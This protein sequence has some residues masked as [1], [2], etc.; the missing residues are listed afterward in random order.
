[1][2][3]KCAILTVTLGLSTLVAGGIFFLVSVGLHDPIWKVLGSVCFCL[4]ALFCSCGVAG[5]CY[6]IRRAAAI[7]QW[8]SYTRD[9]MDIFTAMENPSYR[10]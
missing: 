1:M 3:H 4:G 9:E 6:V 2:E 7:G 5:W 8:K 10:R